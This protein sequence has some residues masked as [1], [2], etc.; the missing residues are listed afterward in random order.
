MSLTI[1]STGYGLIA[2]PSKQA[3]QVTLGD[4]IGPALLLCAMIGLTFL[5]LSE[6][7]WGVL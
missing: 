3:R 6:R 5:A 7:V 4:W 2:S 1:R